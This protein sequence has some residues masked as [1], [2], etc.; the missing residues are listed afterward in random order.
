VACSSQEACA[1]EP[2]LREDGACGDSLLQAK[3][4][5]WTRANSSFIVEGA[6]KGIKLFASNMTAVSGNSDLAMSPDDRILGRFRAYL[7]LP[8]TQFLTHR[9][10]MATTALETSALQRHWVL[11]GAGIVALVIVLAIVQWNFSDSS[12]IHAVCLG[13]LYII[14]SACMIES[15][16]WLMLPGHFPYPL[17]L[18]SNHMLMS[19]VLANCLRAFRPAAFPA[20]QQIEVDRWL[21]LKFIPI[22]AAFALSMVS[23]NAA[24]QYLSVSFLQIMKQCNIATIYTFSV[25]CGLEALRRCSVM[26]LLITLCGIILAVHGELHFDLTGFLLQV[27][28]SLAEATRIIILGV[29]MRGGYKLD[30]MTMV[31]FMAPACLLVNIVPFVFLEGPELSV[32]KAQ[33]VMLLPYIV[34]NAALAFILNCITASCIKQLS[35]VGYLLCGI[36]K[37]VCIIVSSAYLL[38]ESLSIQQIYGFILALS[39][40]ASYSLYKQNSDC[41]ED[42]QLL[43]GFSRVAHRLFDSP[44]KV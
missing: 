7:A 1:S 6:D 44:S 23:A 9:S 11:L 25:L 5:R 19:L 28:S 22:G 21:C 3:S 8:E 12:V 17:T 36:V 20:L 4:E 2:A 15:N 16:K 10:P 33:L 37:D 41:F 40:V 31:L 13:S 26:L 34:A 42:D 38:G 43:H 32:I 14:V 39:G 30:P 18:A 35:P 27:T 24:Y 29:L